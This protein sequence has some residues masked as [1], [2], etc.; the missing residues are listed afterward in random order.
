MFDTREKHQTLKEAAKS[1]AAYMYD[2]VK[3]VDN[4]TGFPRKR[5]GSQ[6]M[7]WKSNKLFLFMSGTLRS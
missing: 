4:K 3:D 5:G 6:Q 2:N 7:S 1:P